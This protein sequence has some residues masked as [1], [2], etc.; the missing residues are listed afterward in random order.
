MLLPVVSYV[1]IRLAHAPAML[2][3]ADDPAWRSVPPV[4]AFTQWSPRVGA[5]PSFRTE[6][7]V[8]YDERNL[9]VLVRAFDPHPDSI[10]H[11]VTRRDGTSASDEIG[12]YID[13]NH[14]RRSGYEFYVNAA[15]VQ[16]DVAISGDSREDVTWDAVWSAVA[17]VDSLGWVAEFRI[18]FSQ[19]RFPPSARHSFGFLVD[20]SIQR[21][22]ENVSW[23]AYEPSKPGIVSQFGVL[24]GIEGIVGAPSMEATPFV[25]A[26]SRGGG[27]V[28]TGADVRVRPTSSM[29]VDATVFPD[30]G[31]VEADPSVVNLTSIETFYP[32]HRPFF[33]DGGGTFRV[34]FN[35]MSFLC[36]NE[37]LFYSRR[38]GRAPQLASRYG[39]ASTAAAPILAAAKLTERTADGMTIGVMGANTGRVGS[40]DAQTLEPE[41]RYGMGRVVF[42]S[43]DGQS[44]ASAVMTV[45][46]RE[47]DRWS[48][49]YLTKSAV[50]GGSAFRH[51]FGG[52]QY[53]VWGSGSVSRL[54]GSSS[55]IAV[56]QENGVHY[57]QRVDDSRLDTTRT[58]LVGDQEELAVGKYGGPLFFELAYERQSRGYETNDMGYLQRADEQTFEAW[59]GYRD[60]V[61]RGIYKTWWA[62][63]NHWDS[64]NAAGLRIESAVNGNA[65]MILATNWTL[66][67]G[68]TL[69][70]L[71]APVC[72][73]CARGGPGMR[74]DPVLAAFVDIVGDSRARVVPELFVPATVGDGGRSRSVTLDPSVSLR[75][76]PQLQ[77]TAGLVVGIN[78]NNTQ[79]LGNFA[80]SAGT[81]Y[82]FGRISQWTK[83]VTLRG[84][85][86]ATPFLSL[87]T[88]VAPFSSSGRYSA[89]RTLSSTPGAAS[90]DDRF[91][92]YAPPTG[93]AAN[94]D[95]RQLHATTVLRW[96]YSPGST[97][98][99]VWANETAIGNTLTAK[100]SY[101]IGR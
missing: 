53:E 21:R 86:A 3:N 66:N 50:V 30:F 87:E 33:L 76:L 79:W 82:S 13:A 69:S 95:V 90:Y 101:W 20:R 9:Y 39:V 58:S 99:L 97:L 57:L 78:D 61:P 28:A 2:A 26:A 51:R 73:H 19:L 59:L 5:E 68:A 32:E 6:F 25:R 100:A 80:D 42:D 35:C 91:V 70:Q 22:A 23:P 15:G 71:G 47:L 12:I 44:G 48:D 94:F 11:T 96:E 34:G 74:S 31:Q 65:H 81:N 88:Y 52:G 14:D 8:A 84:S 18:P 43:R 85:Y 46:D 29:N 4:S 93:T 16:R 49:P 40:A 56:I 75:A 67:G 72:D 37:G 77:F 36:A 98:F 92:A 55:S 17:R 63:L 83:T 60:R 41:T 45:V 89:A 54:G 1:A 38:I 10:V 7:R 64:W 24:D 27:A 62:N